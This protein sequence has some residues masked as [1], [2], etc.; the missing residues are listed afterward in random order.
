[1][2]ETTPTLR[3]GLKHAP[4]DVTRAIIIQL[5]KMKASQKELQRIINNKDDENN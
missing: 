4:D 1:M 2:K 5:R 3:T